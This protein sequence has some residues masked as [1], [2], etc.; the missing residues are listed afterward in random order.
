MKGQSYFQL[1]FLAFNTI[2]TLSTVVL[3][4]YFYGSQKTTSKKKK[5]DPWQEEKNSKNWFQ[6]YVIDALYDKSCELSKRSSILATVVAFS[7]S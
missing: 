2:F 4:Y 5:V 3:Y 6:R 1:V 7:K